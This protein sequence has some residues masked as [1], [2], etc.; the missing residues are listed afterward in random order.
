M[1]SIEKIMPLFVTLFICTL[2]GYSMMS[3]RLSS[4]KAYGCFAAVTVFCLALNSCIIVRYGAESLERIMLF[5]IALPYFALILAITSD[6]VSQTVF[7]FWLWINVYEVIA[8]FSAFVN[9][10]TY[11]SSVFRTALRAVLLCIYFVLYNR[12]L[13]KAH[14]QLMESVE[15]NWW[16]FSFIPMLFAMLIA[17]VNYNYANFTS[18]AAMHSILT[19]IHV[20]MIF[21]YILIFYSFKTAYSLMKRERLAQSMKEQI[22]LQKKQYE[23]YRHRSESER[24]FRHDAKHRDSVLLGYLNCGDVQRAKELLSSEMSEIDEK[25]RVCFCENSVINAVLTEYFLK[26]KKKEIEFSTRIK[27]PD[28]LLCDEAEFCVMLSNL[29]ENSIYA[30]KRFIRIEIRALNR[31]L[32]LSIKNDYDSE[33]KKNADGGYMTTKPNGSGLGLLSV[34]EILKKNG[35]FLKITDDGGEFCVYATMQN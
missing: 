9:D 17:L 30:A 32:S 10:Y 22:T 20:L 19:A 6:K 27:M 1:S 14:R 5:T 8:N 25:S 24:I 13:K 18:A 28:R 4:N 11:Q 29:L 7:N 26:A 33:V 35:G 15:V 21:V 3:Y 31:Q 16:V 2:D 34:G 23:A 12:V